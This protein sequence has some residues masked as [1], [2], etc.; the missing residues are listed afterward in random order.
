MIA[1]CDYGVKGEEWKVIR[2]RQAKAPAE[3]SS[4]QCRSKSYD[5]SVGSVIA[6]IVSLS[7][8]VWVQ[9]RIQCWK[10]A[11][12]SRGCLKREVIVFK[13]TREWRVAQKS[14]T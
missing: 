14:A 9:G 13:R 7:D 3:Y 12:L 1:R 11:G 10:A 4:D 2:R 6:V 5:C 8:E